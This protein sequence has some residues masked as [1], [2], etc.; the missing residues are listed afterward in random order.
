[1]MVLGLL[2]HRWLVLR[3]CRLLGP[4]SG[5]P[6]WR[7]VV[8]PRHLRRRRK[9]GRAGGGSGLHQREAMSGCS[10]IAA[11]ACCGHSVP[12]R[13]A[14]RPQ[15]PARRPCFPPARAC[16]T[17]H[18]IRAQI[19][20]RAAFYASAGAGLAGLLLTLLFLPDT[21]GLDLHEIDR[22]NGYLLAGQ[23]HNYHGG[24]CSAVQRTASRCTVPVSLQCG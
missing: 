2:R 22:M 24:L 23:L 12:P 13:T 6:N 17:H 20:E 10:G 5:V 3:S 4:P 19:S 16:P 1:M 14:S 7:E 15:L 18:F 11:G 8:F 9:S 21:T